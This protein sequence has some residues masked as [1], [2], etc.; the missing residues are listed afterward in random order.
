[1]DEQEKMELFKD[2]VEV[3]EAASNYHAQRQVILAAQ[4]FFRDNPDL[5][6]DS[7]L[8]GVEVARIP[9]K[10][11]TDPYDETIRRLSEAAKRVRARKERLYGPDALRQDYKAAIA[12]EKSGLPTTKEA[13]AEIQTIWTDTHRERQKQIKRRF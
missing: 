9:P 2:A 10:L 6:E 1:M 12:Y 11:N 5:A 8:I 13:E 3:T 7:D 4:A